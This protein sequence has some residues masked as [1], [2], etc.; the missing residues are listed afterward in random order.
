MPRV[1]ARGKAYGKR[2]G[3]VWTAYP[4]AADEAGHDPG[5]L[6]ECA[7]ID[8]SQLSRMENGHGNPKFETLE[9]IAGALKVRSHELLDFSQHQSEESLRADIV[10]LLDGLN[11]ESLRV[12]HRLMRYMVR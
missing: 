1:E 3:T 6:A 5:K 2:S 11:A 9:R 10:T 7:G 8:L 4:G 12:V